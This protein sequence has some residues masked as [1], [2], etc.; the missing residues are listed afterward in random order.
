MHLRQLRHL[1][2]IFIIIR[3]CDDTCPILAYFSRPT[4]CDHLPKLSYI[5]SQRLLNDVHSNFHFLLFSSILLPIHS[6]SLSSRLLHSFCTTIAIHPSVTCMWSHHQQ[7][8]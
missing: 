6:H 3:W 4:S 1:I 5:A 7:S 2:I 8:V